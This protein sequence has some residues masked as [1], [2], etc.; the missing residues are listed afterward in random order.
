MPVK[1]RTAITLV[2]MLAVPALAGPSALTGIRHMTPPELVHRAQFIGIVR[3][4]RVSVG[5]PFLKRRRATATILDSWK[6]QPN[7]TVTFRA[8]PASRFDVS[9]AK[10]G[11]EAVVFIEGGDLL[12]SGQGRMPIFLREGRRLAAMPAG[13]SWSGLTAESGPDPQNGNFR[14]VGVE[15]LHDVVVR[16]VAGEAEAR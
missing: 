1:S 2:T 3:I 8:S 11:E 14:G 16:L 9:D 6:G 5:I 15:A 4:E 12:Y 13:W 7:G 10:R